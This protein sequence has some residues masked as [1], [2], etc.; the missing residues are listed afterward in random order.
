M[1][2]ALY[3][4]YRP[5]IVDTHFVNKVKLWTCIFSLLFGA[6]HYTHMHSLLGDDIKGYIHHKGRIKRILLGIYYWIL[7]KQSR[8]VFCIW[9]G[10]RL[11]I[12]DTLFLLR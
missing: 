10:F 6:K 3:R 2:Q 7:T 9:Q 11:P 8:K 1:Y 4:K 5:T 12:Q